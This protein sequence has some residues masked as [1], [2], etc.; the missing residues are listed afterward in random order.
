MSSR[1]LVFQELYNALKAS[2]P[3][4]VAGGVS[5]TYEILS[6]FPE[7]NPV[8]PCIVINPV[9][10][11]TKNLGISLMNSTERRELNID[12]DFYALAAHGKTSI[13][14]ARDIVQD[15]I[16]NLNANTFY[17]S[18]NIPYED[19][20]VDVIDFNALK[21]NTATIRCYLVERI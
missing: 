10:R 13:D 18:H 11:K 2:P 7:S 19:S 21:Y 12:I 5:Y 14:S 8:F 20:S 1:V 4:Y 16:T 3:T 9:M 15:L 6:A 17:I